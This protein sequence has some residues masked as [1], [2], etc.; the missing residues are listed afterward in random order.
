MKKSRTVLLL[1]FIISLA[2]CGQNKSTKEKLINKVQSFS[3]CLDTKVDSLNSFEE[4]AL[5]VIKLNQ[6]HRFEI[7]P[8]EFKYNGK[9][10]RLGGDIKELIKVFGKE[11]RIVRHGYAYVWDNYGFS[12]LLNRHT[13][14]TSEF[15]ICFDCC[16]WI[17]PSDSTST[18]PYSC[19]NGGIQIDGIALGNGVPFDDFR[20]QLKETGSEVDFEGFYRDNLYIYSY[21]C[22]YDGNIKSPSDKNHA[23]IIDGKKEINQYSSVHLNDSRAIHKLQMEHEKE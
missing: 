2:A 6:E 1:V 9:V 11:S 8:C 12:V 15:R 19:F 4:E 16:D 23:I 13:K 21:N 3:N 5:P 20:K 14:E 17:K 7:S 10:F 18:L 22:N